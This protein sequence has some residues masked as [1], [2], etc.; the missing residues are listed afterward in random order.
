MQGA[1]AA[2]GSAWPRLPATLDAARAALA[3]SSLLR[4]AER[5]D[6]EALL[7]STRWWPLPKTAS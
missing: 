6:A 7:A 5:L 4:R 3:A 2:T 1:A